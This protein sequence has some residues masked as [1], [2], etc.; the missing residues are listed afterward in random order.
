MVRQSPVHVGDGDVSL[1][2]EAVVLELHRP[3]PR[4]EHRT[5]AVEGPA[6]DLTE[7]TLVVR[8]IN[9]SRRSPRV[10]WD[11]DNAGPRSVNEVDQ[12]LVRERRDESGD[13]VDISRAK[14]VKS[15]TIKFLQCRV[16]LSTKIIL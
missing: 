3:S 12:T 4:L 14:S 5:D 6:P 9:A 11:R 16:Y 2:A 7:E 13:E 10:P 15:Q 1:A 8:Q